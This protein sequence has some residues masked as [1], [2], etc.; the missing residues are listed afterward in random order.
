MYRN[1]SKIHRPFLGDFTVNRMDMFFTYST[2]GGT[3]SVGSMPCGQCTGSPAIIHRL[4]MNLC[5]Y[6]LFYYLCNYLQSLLY[7]FMDNNH[8]CF[9]FNDSIMNLAPVSCYRLRL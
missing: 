9:H 2:G 6:M 8:K 4:R 7:I 1:K 3:T 5:V